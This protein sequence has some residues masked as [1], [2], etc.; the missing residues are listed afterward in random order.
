MLKINVIT[1]SPILRR[2][3]NLKR[4]YR[5]LRSTE[6]GKLLNR[7]GSK[8]YYEKN[9]EIMSERQRVYARNKLAEDH[10]LKNDW[11]EKQLAYQGGHCALCP[12]RPGTPDHKR[13]RLHLDHN[14][15]TGMLRGLLCFRCNHSLGWLEKL[16]D[17]REKLAQYMAFIEYGLWSAR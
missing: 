9:R 12:A 3:I 14:H 15:K 8:A 1:L 7:E 2:K 4:Y 10:A 5:K 11:Y 13:G 16:S 17:N 6:E